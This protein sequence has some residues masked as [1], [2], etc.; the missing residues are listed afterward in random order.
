LKSKKSSASRYLFV[1]VL[2]FI[3]TVIM[4]CKTLDLRFI[5]HNKE[6]EVSS[7][8]QLKW[9][10]EINLLQKGNTCGAHSV[11]AIQYIIN[12]TKENPYSI[13]DKIDE[14]LGNGYLYPWGLT[15]YLKSK[16][17]KYKVNYLG[18]LNK[19]NR[20]DFLKRKISGN[21]PV[22]VVVG[23]EKY[24]HYVSVVGYDSISFFVYDSLVKD[25]MNGLY[26][27]NVNIGYEELITK[28]KDAEWKGI[29]LNIAI[30]N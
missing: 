8:K 24:L 25:D 13:Y 27:G 10:N 9:S 2:M 7:T 20:V 19:R 29:K 21:N 18:F 26:V 6:I 4:G 30:S 5:L 14:K 23:N 11:M 12:G 17:I 22:I 3:S 28:M 15:R 16:G 1:L